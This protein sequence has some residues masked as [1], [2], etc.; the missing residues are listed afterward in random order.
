MQNEPNFQKTKMNVTS[1]KA[2]HYGNNRFPGRR[3]NEPKTNPIKANLRKNEPNLKLYST[4]VS[5]DYRPFA[6]LY[7][8]NACTDLN[9]DLI[10]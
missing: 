9:D 10:T 7:C 1:I 3:Q 8:V 6:A 2:S 5:L 4:D